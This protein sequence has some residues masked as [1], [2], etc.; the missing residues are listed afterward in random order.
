[1]MY[2][3][4][5]FIFLNLPQQNLSKSVFGSNVTY[6]LKTPTALFC[7]TFLTRQEKQLFPPY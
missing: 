5:R 7:Q 2:Y 6:Q 4:Q 3:K 1:M